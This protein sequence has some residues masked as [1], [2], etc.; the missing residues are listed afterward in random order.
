MIKTTI[1]LFLLNL[2]NCLQQ[3]IARAQGCQFGNMPICMEQLAFTTDK[4]KIVAC[5][6]DNTD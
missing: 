6:Y 1:I 3:M 2:T 5:I 4:E